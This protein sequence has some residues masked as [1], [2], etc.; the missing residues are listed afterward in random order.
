M[1][2]SLDGYLEPTRLSLTTPHFSHQPITSPSE[3]SFPF[4]SPPP[5]PALRD[6]HAPTRASAPTAH[7]IG[8]PWLREHLT[9]HRPSVSTTSPV[10]SHHTYSEN[11]PGEL[12]EPKELQSKEELEDPNSIESTTRLLESAAELLSLARRT[13]FFNSPSFS[14]ESQDLGTLNSK[15]SGL[16]AA[17]MKAA[18]Y[19]LHGNHACLEITV[20]HVSRASR[21]TTNI[22]VEKPFSN[23]LLIEMFHYYSPTMLL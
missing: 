11:S 14:M 6:R 2:L 16:R 18:Q 8:P 17:D 3:E 7:D 19:L 20:T 23:S 10:M 1:T 4:F 12:E 13:R 22:S 5:Y 9:Y 21:A 15:T